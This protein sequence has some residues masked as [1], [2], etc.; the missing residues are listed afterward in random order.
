M[1]FRKGHINHITEKM[2]DGKNVCECVGIYIYVY[3]QLC[4][5]LLRIHGPIHIWRIALTVGHLASCQT[6][7][8]DFSYFLVGPQ[9]RHAASANH[10]F[11]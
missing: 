2:L 5:S 8:T 3:T 11:K 1:L 9:V 4:C 7:P 10:V 6:T